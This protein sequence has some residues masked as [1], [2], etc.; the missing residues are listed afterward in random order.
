MSETLAGWQQHAKT[1]KPHNLA[2]ING[3]FVAA[4]SGKT[5]ACI[6]PATDEII[7]HV[8]ECDKADIDLAV[9]AARVAFERGEW[10][11]A[12]TAERKAVLN[13]LADLIEKHRAEFA[14]LD[15]MDMGKA[16]AYSYHDD[17]PMAAATFRYYGESLDKIYDEIAPLPKGCLGMI[18]REAL[19]VVGA[20][21]PWNYPLLMA[22]WKVAPAL[23][24]GNSVVLKPAE[25]SPLSVLLLAQLLA[26]AGLPKGV[27]NVVTGYGETCGRALGLHPDVDCLA[28]TGST[29]VGKYFL[30]Y[31]GQS[32]MKQV[33]LECGG[34]SPNII[35][36]DADLSAA[37]DNAARGIWYNQGEVCSANSRLI[38]EESIKDEFVAML[39]ERRAGY[40]PKNP[41]DPASKMGPLVDRN[42]LQRVLRYIDIGKKSA[43]LVAGGKAAP[44]DGRGC[45]VEPT[46]FD[47][48]DN[49]STIAQEEI[50][51]PVLA[52]MTFKTEDQ[53]L[54]MANNSIY[55]LAGS[56][57]TN[58]LSRAHHF[59][60]KLKV[61]S[62]SINNVDAGDLTLPFGGF[63]Q[64]GFGRDLSL[65]A[66]DKYTSLKTIFISY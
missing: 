54:A 2:F 11:Q 6:N 8:A 25:Q 36:A 49:Q 23:A 19:G 48:V 15:T 18:R 66:L 21:V 17:V 34:K 63:K 62:V 53:A 57:W 61:G 24:T 50:F 12:G 9:K 55:G 52:V 32:N 3:E 33:W 46:I 7:T 30:E 28:F 16:I 14:L 20:V 42:Q 29:E 27:F 26:E 41:L 43:Q 60:D 35:F 37:A 64:S 38:I 22:V 65:H 51:G 59:A 31:S 56:V 45:F 4:Q 47:G 5:F 40:L 39:V 58:N 44:I 1:I 10:S 13:K